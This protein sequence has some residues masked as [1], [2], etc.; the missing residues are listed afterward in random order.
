MSRSLG[1]FAVVF[2]LA[3]TGLVAVMFRYEVIPVSSGLVAQADRWTGR[4][5]FIE[6]VGAGHA[7][8]RTV[9]APP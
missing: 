7:P 2:L 5:C 1:A 4:V 3:C 6:Y 9:G 8:A